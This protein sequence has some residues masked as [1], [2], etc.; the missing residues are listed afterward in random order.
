MR[1]QAHERIVRANHLM[2]HNIEDVLVAVD[3][4]PAGV[5]V[6]DGL[7]LLQPAA[8]REGVAQA[9]QVHQQQA[10]VQS[11]LTEVR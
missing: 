10:G 1:H 6:D 8:P 3:E 9:G 11:R 5:L 4:V 2:E 7:D